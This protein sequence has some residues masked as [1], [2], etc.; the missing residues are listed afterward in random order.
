MQHKP[1][2]KKNAALVN[3][4][5]G[6]EPIFQI[7]HVLK[8]KYNI[9]MC[10]GDFMRVLFTKGWIVQTKPRTAKKTKKAMTD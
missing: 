1:L 4:F 6:E 3:H 2:M 8:P 10:C 9:Y 7:L 5:W